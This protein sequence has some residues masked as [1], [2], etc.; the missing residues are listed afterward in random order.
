MHE[1]I[2]DLSLRITSH[3]QIILQRFTIQ[4]QS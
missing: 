4:K 2:T 1:K 3:A